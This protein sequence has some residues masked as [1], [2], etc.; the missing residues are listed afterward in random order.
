MDPL[1]KSYPELTP[2]QFASNRPIDAVDLDGAEA[3]YKDPITGQMTMPSDAIRHP[4]PPGAY[5]PSN[6]AARGGAANTTR[7]AIV[8]GGVVATV[9]GA[10]IVYALA[11]RAFWSIAIWAS[12]PGNQMTALSVA[13]FTFNVLNPDPGTQ[14]DLG[15]PSKVGSY[16]SLALRNRSG[17]AVQLI[18]EAGSKLDGAEQYWVGRLLDEGKNVGIL[19]ESTVK[20]QRT[21]DFIVNGVKTELKTIS[22]ITADNADDLSDAIRNVIKGSSGQA[23]TVI[24]D[25]RNQAGATLDIMKRAAARYF[26]SGKTIDNIRVVGKGFDQVL[27]R[28]DYVKKTN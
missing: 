18:A 23:K 10:P 13:G 21:A 17:K 6:E 25:V 15:G 3:S 26:N 16:V 7:G 5:M 8:V 27:Q 2:Y 20:N 24:A 12:V 11:G 14:I 9:V 28:S 19:A 4:I 22:N 1:T